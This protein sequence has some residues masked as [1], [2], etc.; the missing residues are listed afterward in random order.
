MYDIVTADDR[1]LAQ[2]MSYEEATNL[3]DALCPL[4]ETLWVKRISSIGYETV[5]V[6]GGLIHL[7]RA[8][9]ILD[10]LAVN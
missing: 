7:P 8:S 5:A 6:I 3:A 9:S 10:S 2:S 4:Y 1:I